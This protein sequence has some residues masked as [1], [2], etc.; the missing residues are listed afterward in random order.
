MEKSERLHIHE[1]CV[2][3][4]R[5]TPKGVEFCLVST[6]PGNRWEFPK[7]ETAE[8]HYPEQALLERAA[9]G[10]GLG[11]R[12]ESD[13]PLDAFVAARGNLA[14]SMTAYL[15]RVTSVNDDWP[16]QSTHRRLWCLAEEARVRLRRKPLRRF[17]D[18]ALRSVGGAHAA[19][20]GGRRQVDNRLPRRPR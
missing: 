15:M 19:V 20:N 7:T 11:G 2:V 8:D 9:G 18:M 5:L 17:I 4:Y 3:P 10:A 1:S 16:G 6:I 14:R 13:G 12:L